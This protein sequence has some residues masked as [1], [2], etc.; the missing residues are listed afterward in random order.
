M[1]KV[2]LFIL[3]MLLFITPVSAKTYKLTYPDGSIYETEDYDEA[4]RLLNEWKLLKS[5][6]SDENGEI[7]LIDWLEE[8]EIK[9]VET[10]IPDGYEVDSTETITNLKNREESIIHRKKS[11]EST[12]NDKKEKPN[13]DPIPKKQERMKTPSTL[14]KIIIDSELLVISMLVMGI[15]IM[16][17]KRAK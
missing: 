16:L 2:M 3:L 4:Q 14:D 13:V 8:G 7:I 1:K 17:I 6:V 12:N 9:I 5:G 10:L 15:M 11:E